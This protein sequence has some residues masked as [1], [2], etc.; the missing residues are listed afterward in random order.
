[1]ITVV[2]I[3][4]GAAANQTLAALEAIKQ[5]EVLVGGKRHL[6]EFPSFNGETRRL[7]ADMDGLMHWLE[8]NQHRPIVVLASGDPLFMALAS[9]SPN[10]LLGYMQMD[11]W[12]SK[13]SASFLVSVRFNICAPVCCWT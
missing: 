7:N 13:T 9:G 3:G 4:P 1:M 2:G 6:A 11:K 8:Q 12:M 10:I 5:A